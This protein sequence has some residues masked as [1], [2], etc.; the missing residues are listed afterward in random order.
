MVM[1]HKAQ[2]P[3]QFEITPATPD[4]VRRGIKPAG[5]KSG[6]FLFPSRLHESP[7]CATRQDARIFEDRV[8][9]LGRDPAD[10]GAHSM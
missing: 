4:A 2:R 3:V 6:D 10:C 9:E 7:H 1:Q 5:L 8:Q